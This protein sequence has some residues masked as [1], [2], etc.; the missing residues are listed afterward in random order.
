VKR[1]LVA[2]L[3]LLAACG[4]DSP[5]APLATTLTTAALPSGAISVTI[6][7][8]PVKATGDPSMPMLATWTLL[9]HESAGVGGRLTLVNITVRDAGSGARAGPRGNTTMGTEALV[10]LLGSDRL[11]GGGSLSVPGSLRYGFSSGGKVGI[12]SVAVQ[13][14][15]D[16]DHLLSAFAEA[17][18]R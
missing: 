15:D 12:L 10:A 4:E 7:A 16:N 2:A 11:P 1:A 17:E 5:T 3:L 9:V 18:L 8:L 6:D 13:V 14:Q